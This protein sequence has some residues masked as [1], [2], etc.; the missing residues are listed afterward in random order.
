MDKYW[1][2][3]EGEELE[4]FLKEAPFNHVLAYKRDKAEWAMK[5]SITFYGVCE[6]HGKQ[7]VTVHKDKTALCTFCN[8]ELR[9]S[10]EIEDGN[11]N[12][13]DYV[14]VP[15]YLDKNGMPIAGAPLTRVSKR[16]ASTVM[17]R[18]GRERVD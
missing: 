7:K 3:L 15:A 8:K 1:L 11:I 9:Y 17:T 12:S 18:R 5:N 6:T 13:R 16:A 14:N 2:H 4:T 10:D